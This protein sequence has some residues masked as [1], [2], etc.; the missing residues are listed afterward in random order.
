MFI[1]QDAQFSRNLTLLS[2]LPSTT[3]LLTVMLHRASGITLAKNGITVQIS[4]L[5][6]CVCVC[7][8]WQS[9]IARAVCV[10]V[11]LLASLYVCMKGIVYGR[12][13]HWFNTTVLNR[14]VVGYSAAVIL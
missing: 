5:C 3:S 9:V 7:G 1:I 10:V 11:V 4:L 12:L 2:V 14:S 13:S 6:V 8:M